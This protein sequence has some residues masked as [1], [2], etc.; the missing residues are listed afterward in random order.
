M[1][2]CRLEKALKFDQYR[3]DTLKAAYADSVGTFKNITLKMQAAPQ[4]IN[5]VNC[6]R[7]DMPFVGKVFEIRESVTTYLQLD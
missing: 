4:I 7:I 1:G 5:G 3:F 6:Y 2:Q